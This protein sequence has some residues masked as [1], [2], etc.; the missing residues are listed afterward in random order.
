MI[1]SKEQCAEEGLPGVGGRGC[2]MPFTWLR[3]YFGIERCDS[4]GR[5]EKETLQ[6]NSKKTSC[7]KTFTGFS[8]CLQGRGEG[9]A[10]VANWRQTKY[11]FPIHMRS[12]ENAVRNAPRGREGCRERG[13]TQGQVRN[14][15]SAARR[16]P[17]A[18]MCVCVCELWLLLR[19]LAGIN[20]P[21]AAIKPARTLI[22]GPLCPLCQAA[23][24]RCPYVAF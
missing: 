6:P 4:T 1:P 11:E 19:I 10:G 22:C 21:N 3:N 5:K 16:H 20:E 17:H 13:G 18:G 7:P 15:E 12:S 23:A 24:D 9:A 8:S 14:C 2:G